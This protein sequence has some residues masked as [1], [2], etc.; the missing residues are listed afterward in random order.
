VELKF[1]KVTSHVGRTVS[2]SGGTTIH[3]DKGQ[4][5]PEM[6]L[7]KFAIQEEINL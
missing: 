1:P 7:V 3:W 4:T 6:K 5:F 2:I